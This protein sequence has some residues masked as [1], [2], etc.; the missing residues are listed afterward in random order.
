MNNF[1]RPTDDVIHESVLRELIQQMHNYEE[2]TNSAA[3]GIASVSSYFI[4]DDAQS[5][6]YEHACESIRHDLLQS[7]RGIEVCESL[8]QRAINILHN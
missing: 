6:N 5:R 3:A 2:D 7:I 8:L 1:W 4:W